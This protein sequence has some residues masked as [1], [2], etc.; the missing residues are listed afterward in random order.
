MPESGT[1]MGIALGLLAVGVLVLL[2]AFFVAA[3]FALV[4]VRRTRIEELIAQ[5]VKSASTVRKAIHNPDQF[6]AATQLGITLASLGLG[7]VG[8]PALSHLIDP[9]I[10][11]LPLPASWAATTSHTIS[12]AIA[13]TVITFLHVVIGELAPKSIA[14]QRPE[15]TSLF[16]AGPTMIAETLFRPGIWA[17][18]G[19]GN[20]VLRALGFR[21]ASGHEMAHSFEEIRMLVDASKT[22]G[23]LGESEHDMLSAIFDLRALTV[24]QVMVPRTEMITIQAG[25]TLQQVLE[26]LHESQYTKLPV[27][28]KDPDHIVGILHMRDLV[29]G[30]ASGDLS[31]PIRPYIRQALFLPESARIFNALRALREGRQHI[32]IVLDEYGGTGGLVTLEDILEK[33][34][35]EVP[36]EFEQGSPEI[37]QVPDGSWLVSGLA[38]IEDVNAALGVDLI[39]ENY[40]TIG[41]FVMGRLERIPV[42]GDQVQAGDIHF[43]VEQI[44]GM[45]IDLLR[46]QVIRSNT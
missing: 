1:A 14:L 15:E 5:G 22:H 25:A 35:G 24:R 29:G 33:I 32:A 44:D 27:F 31:A 6:I 18:N 2:N 39:D 19:A 3:E 8:E 9:V 17:L 7:W 42:K 26:T 40:D 38:Q 10:A 30:L 43:R 4:S 12:A 45:R 13:F 46:I 11:I 21:L 23:V 41:G 34:S 37:V 20:A 36:D 28:E 16:V